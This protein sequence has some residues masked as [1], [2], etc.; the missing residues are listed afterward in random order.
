M[1]DFEREA[2]P[3]FEHRS[4]EACRSAAEHRVR[5]GEIFLW[6]DA[7]ESVCMAGL[8]RPTRNGVT[9]NAVYTPPVSRESG[10]ATRLVAHLSQRALDA[11]RKFC[12]LYTDLLNPTSNR[13]YRKIGYRPVCDSRQYVFI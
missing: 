10:F 9:V 5:E 7:E 4:A 6:T 2:L 12:V 11:G 8:A 3:T 1:A 13:I